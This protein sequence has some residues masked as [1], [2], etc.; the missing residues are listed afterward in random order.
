MYLAYCT[1]RGWSRPYLANSTSL[2]WGVSLSSAKGV[3]GSALLIKNVTLMITKSVTNIIT[4]RRDT[5]LNI[6][7]EP[8]NELRHKR[9]KRGGSESP[10]RQRLT[11]STDLR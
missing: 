3:P 11:H 4:S 1:I 2:D 7:S 6:A 5:Y 8:P 9:R 10:T